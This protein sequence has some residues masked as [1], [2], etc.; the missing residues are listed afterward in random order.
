MKTLVKSGSKISVLILFFLSAC[1]PQKKVNEI[2]SKFEKSEQDRKY[3]QG[4]NR[5]LETENTELKAEIA[6]LKERML[7]VQTD[8]AQLG[9]NLRKI[10]LQA[11][12]LSK[13]NDEL[14]RNQ[15]NAQKGSEAENR[16]LLD[17]LKV[18]QEEL[19]I[20]EDD[21]KKLEKELNDKS[22]NLTKLSNELAKRE[23]KIEE[24]QRIIEEKDAAVNTLKE[25]V[26]QALLGFKDKGLTVEQSNGR[27]KVSMEAKLL[28]PKGST[29]IDPEGAKALT[30]LAKVLE[31]YK[32]ITVLVEG[33][34]DTDPIKGSATMKDNWDLSVLRATAVVR[35]MIEKSK[36]D[37]TMLTAA[38]RSEFIPVD[39]GESEAEK[40]KNRRIE[41]LLSPNLD[42]L[43]EILEKN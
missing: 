18:M 36:L 27:I 3:L 11:D 31:D 19:I 35:L 5:R 12:R 32:D 39:P 38:G 26:Q 40:S 16:K 37:P 9:L 17:E 43:F 6:D 30:E 34:T 7:K 2:E 24:L 33:H 15:A 22:T 25:K 21:L 10:Q 42:K 20:K 13:I 41:I 14:L 8:T 4:E 28:F 23:K 1:V 29:N